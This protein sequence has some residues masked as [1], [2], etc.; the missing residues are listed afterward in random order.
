MPS[1]PVPPAGAVQAQQA[2]FTGLLEQWLRKYGPSAGEGGP[3]LFVREVLGAEPDQWQQECLAAYGRGERGMSIVSCHGPGKTAFAAWCIVHQLCC[4]FPQKTACTAPTGG[5]LYDALGS[6]VRKWIRKLPAEIQQCL[7]VTTQRIELVPAP[8]LSFVTFRTAKAEQPEAI[9]GIHCDDGFVLL[10]GDEA[11][12]I[13]EQ[14]FEAGA[15]SMSGTNTTTL[16]LSNG[17]RANGYFY[18]THHRLKDHWFRR[19]ISHHDSPRV[20]Q[21]FVDEI[22]RRYGVDSNQYRVRCMGQ[23]PRSDADTIIPRD[24]V[25]SAIGRDIEASPDLQVVWGLDV[26]REGGDKTVLTKR[27]GKV[28]VEPQKYWQERDTMKT[29]ARLAAEVEAAESNSLSDVP[30]AIYVDTL[31]MG[32][33][34]VDRSKELGL[35]VVGIN[36]S[37]LPAAFKEQYRNVRTELWFA[38]RDW[39]EG[40][41]CRLPPIERPGDRDD[42]MVQLIDQLSR[43]KQ[44]FTTSTAQVIAESKKKQKARGLDSPDFADSFILTFARQNSVVSGAYKMSRNLA[45]KPLTRGRKWVV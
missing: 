33:A 41:D 10:V 18:E 37:E 22:V 28:L 14:I 39:F 5:Q 35:P 23:F 26:A 32:Y 3:E 40:R 30:A 36:V 2:Q 9:Q 20:S 15:G 38:A 45:S 11:S 17:T 13:P 19:A 8:E 43:T 24:W 4:R 12:G 1:E 6:E 16:L 31:S 21:E 44:E 25:E 7:N 42:P 27:R 29:V 34:V